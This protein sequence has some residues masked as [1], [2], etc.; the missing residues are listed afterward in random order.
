MDGKPFPFL[1]RLKDSLPYVSEKPVTFTLI[2]AEIFRVVQTAF[3]AKAGMGD[4]CKRV[5]KV[6]QTVC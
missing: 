4:P 6:D 3:R 5:A 2:D 1:M